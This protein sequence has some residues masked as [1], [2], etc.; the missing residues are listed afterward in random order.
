MNYLTDKNK[1]FLENTFRTFLGLTASALVG[2]L[3]TSCSES[4]EKTSAYQAACH[5]APLR[6]PEQMNKAMED[7]YV[8]NRQYRCIDKA[9]FAAV[10]V[11]K[12]KWDA[13]NTPQ[14]KAE[15]QAEFAARRERDAAE[16]RQAVVEELPKTEVP[17]IVLP[18]VDVNTASESDIASV[19][20]IGPEVAAQIVRERNKRGFA[21]WG[22][23]INRVVGL[24]AAQSAAYASICG[25]NVNGKSLDGAPPNQMLATSL[26][27][28]QQKKGSN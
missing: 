15:R 14:A 28:Q 17:T 18:N 13:A 24:S 6:T 16:R 19:I 27:M 2:V 26:Y 4:V 1:F 21:D 10:A 7:G 23:L 25:L 22:D 20:T 8:I 11:E 12:A 5:G 3:I 9:S